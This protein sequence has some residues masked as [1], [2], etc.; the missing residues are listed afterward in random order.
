MKEIWKD[1]VGYEGLYKVSSLGRV[2]GK[3]GIIK[4]Q[5]N[6][7][8]YPLLHLYKNGV[9]RAYTVHRLVAMAFIPNPEHKPQV[10]HIDGDKSNNNLDNLEWATESENQIHRYHVLGN[11]GYDRQKHV[12]KVKC[13]ETGIVFNSIQEA[14]FHTKTPHSNIVAACRKYKHH[15]TAG[16]YHWEYAN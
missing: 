6:N 2:K 1:V 8:K 16:G 13:I 14:S 3:K 9:S 5:Y 15:H 10:N 12:T 4:T 7:H 11:S